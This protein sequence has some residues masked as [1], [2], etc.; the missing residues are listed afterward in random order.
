MWRATAMVPAETTGD[1]NEK[2]SEVGELDK[3]GSVQ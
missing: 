3:V 2:V 1:P